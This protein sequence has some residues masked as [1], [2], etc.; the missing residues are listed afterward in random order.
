MKK[1]LHKYKDI[2]LYVFFGGCTTIINVIIY[3]I[4]SRV[5]ELST[6]TSTVLAWWVAVLFAYLTNRVMVF[7]S[8]N[9]EIRAILLEFTFF[10]ACRLLTGILD[11]MI[12]FIFV[13]HL[14]WYD[15]IIKFAS[16]LLVIL[17][18]YVAS[19]LLIFKKHTHGRQAKSQ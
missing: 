15:L 3:Y 1:L 9:K 2:I 14:G 13:E 10:V 11:I 5:L 12:M 17:A 19:R 6:V 18:N 16:N 4:S 8:S 7:H